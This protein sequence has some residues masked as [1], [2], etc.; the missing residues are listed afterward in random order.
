MK[1]SSLS[2]VLEAMPSWCPCN[3][4]LTSLC[5]KYSSTIRPPRTKSTAAMNI[6]G[7]CSCDSST[8]DVEIGH[9]H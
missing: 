2:G 8:P 6:G 4:T 5:R 9:I 3:G 7:M 1:R